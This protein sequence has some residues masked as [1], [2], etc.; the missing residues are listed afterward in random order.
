MRA[1]RLRGIMCPSSAYLASDFATIGVVK[2]RFVQ[3]V[4]EDLD[5]AKSTA[6]T[7]G[8]IRRAITSGKYSGSILPIRRPVSSSRYGE[9]EFPRAVS[10]VSNRPRGALTSRPASN[11]VCKRVTPPTARL[12]T[13]FVGQVDQ[14]MNVVVKSRRKLVASRPTG[15]QARRGIVLTVRGVIAPQ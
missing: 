5:G 13:Q 7:R 11:V 2:A 3:S 8:S 6:P 9:I 12:S 1:W 15:V 10:R 14:V 4:R